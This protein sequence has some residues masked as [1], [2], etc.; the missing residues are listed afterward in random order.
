MIGVIG[1]LVGLPLP[2]V[3][4]AREAARRA[5]CVNNLKQIG[6]ALHLYHDQNGCLPAGRMPTYDPRYAGSK[7]PCTS[8]IVDKSSLVRILSMIDQSPLYNSINENLTIFGFKNRT[9]A[10][11]AVDAYACPCDPSS[12]RPRSLETTE[13]TQSGL[14]RPDEPLDGVFTRY[15]GS[16][17]SYAVTAQ[18]NVPNHCLIDPR[19][20]AQCDGVINDTSPITCTLVRDDVSQTMFVDETSTTPLA[21]WDAE[22]V[23]NRYGWYFSGNYGDTLFSSFFPPNA[24]EKVAVAQPGAT[25][26]MH[27]GGLNALLGDGSVRFVK[28]TSDKWACDLY[29]GFLVGAV[30]NSGGWWSG[31]TS[32]G[33]WQRLATRAGGEVVDADGF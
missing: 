4:S 30:P 22:L 19:V 26:S 33:V 1:L 24:F 25:R 27:P 2:A 3:Q 20:A 16:F 23:Y 7:P 12:G 31:L 10:T 13:L 29:S 5:Q 28:E 21:K 32:P 17:G 9:A 18:T 8:M 6:L 14:D 15:S 11:V